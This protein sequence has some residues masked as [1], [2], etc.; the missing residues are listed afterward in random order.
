[1][2]SLPPPPLV[3]V[4]CG[5]RHSLALSQGGRELWAWGWGKYGQLGLMGD[6]RS[7]G[8]PQRVPLPSIDGGRVAV[9]VTAG[10]GL[11]LTGD[12][13]SQYV[14]PRVP[15]P[16]ANEGGSE[17]AGAGAVTAV[18]AIGAESGGAQAAWHVGDVEGGR[19]HTIVAMERNFMRQ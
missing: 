19:W 10:A 12:T 6:T 2:H 3:Q 7:Q 8:L 1:M 9:A 17:A 16:S 11:G 5:G 14:P 13:A 15:L 4:S 18:T